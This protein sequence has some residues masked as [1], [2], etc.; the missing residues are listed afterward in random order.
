M[1]YARHRS[2]VQ[3]TLQSCLK[4]HIN[5]PTP[6][7]AVPTLFAQSTNPTPFPSHLRHQ[8]TTLK[9][10]ARFLSTSTPS[11]VTDANGTPA[12][13]RAGR[14]NH[15]AIAVPN[16]EQA[17]AT[18]QNVLGST[19]SKPQSLPEHGV[20][21]VF[22]QLD[23]TKLE[24]LEPLGDSS[25]ISNYLS[26]NPS[27]GMHHICVEV[28]DIKVRSSVHSVTTYIIQVV[29][30]YSF[31]FSS[32]LL[33]RQTQCQL[34]SLSVMQ[35]ALSHIKNNTGVR[36]LHDE[37]KVGAHGNPVVFLHPKDMSGVLT[38]LEQVPQ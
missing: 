9:A 38:E 36:P 4:F 5:D 37:P 34:T 7:I 32:F 1:M 24:L 8:P 6:T 14:L 3:S 13:V 21:V 20:R 19:V 16:L 15:V 12:G 28:P 11:F 22:V 18:F 29:V 30:F 33:D 10:L 35:D 31:L 26:K 25:P 17:A 27:G 23:N 2:L